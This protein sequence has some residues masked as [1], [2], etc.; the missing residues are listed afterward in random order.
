MKRKNKNVM[1]RI[2]AAFL[3]CTMVFSSFSV[4]IFAEEVESGAE[5]VFDAASS[6]ANLS[7]T[8]SAASEEASAPIEGGWRG[9]RSFRIRR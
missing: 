9:Q 2:L 3:T 8:G 1:S 4:S 5:S 6:E 7:D